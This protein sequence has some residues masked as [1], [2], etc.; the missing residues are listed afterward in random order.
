ME[1][2]NILVDVDI[3]SGLNRTMLA[4]IGEITK[5]LTF[6]EGEEIFHESSPA[7]SLYILTEGE[8]VLQV[9]LSSHNQKISVGMINRSDQCFGWS[10]VI[11]PHY[12]TAT[13]ICQKDSEVLVV[14]GQKLLAILAEEPTAGFQVTLRIA[15]I[16]SGRLRNCRMAL[17]KTL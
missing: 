4:K 10:G 8:I 2:S 1:I 6:H 11:A 16:I 13:A 14:D 9:Q 5:R 7:Q 17:L 15:Q 3:F 12:F